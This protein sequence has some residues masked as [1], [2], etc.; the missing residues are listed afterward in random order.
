[1][2]EV[3]STLQIAQNANDWRRCF[4]LKE[5]YIFIIFNKINIELILS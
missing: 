1:M 2:R 3:D 4:R 5:C